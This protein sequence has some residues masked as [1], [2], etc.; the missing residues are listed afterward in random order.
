MRLKKPEP[1]EKKQEKKDFYIFGIYY[2][3]AVQK[4]VGFQEKINRFG[5][6]N[7]IQVKF[8][9]KIENFSLL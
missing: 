9:K 6:L 8:Q 4:Y 1:L 5:L 2:T 7:V 3:P